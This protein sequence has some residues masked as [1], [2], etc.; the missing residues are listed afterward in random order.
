[1]E[2]DEY[3]LQEDDASNSLQ[4]FRGRRDL[5][6]LSFCVG[7]EDLTAFPSPEIVEIERTK[8]RGVLSP[9]KRFDS[10]R[11]Q[12]TAVLRPQCHLI[13]AIQVGNLL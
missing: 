10:A 4:V 11:K 2:C 6:F 9:R 8:S 12:A 1:M 7:M 3:S 5:G 13:H